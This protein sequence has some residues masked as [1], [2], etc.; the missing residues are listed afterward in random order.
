MINQDNVKKAIAEL[1]DAADIC[2]RGRRAIEALASALT[3]GEYKSAGS[4]KG[5][6]VWSH[7][8]QDYLLI[9]AGDDFDAMNLKTNEVISDVEEYLAEAKLVSETIADYAAGKRAG[10][11]AAAPVAPAKP[12]AKAGQIWSHAGQNYL[13]T[14]DGAGMSAMSLATNEVVRNIGAYVGQ[15]TFVAESLAAFQAK[16]Q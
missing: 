15:A 13:L 16:R 6:Q 14:Q 7:Q 2:Q 11:A 1:V 8:G 3:G 12:V 5:G 10:Q 9:A 4:A